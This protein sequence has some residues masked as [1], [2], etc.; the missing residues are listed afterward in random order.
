MDV[1]N[2]LYQIFYPYDI[3]LTESDMDKLYP[4]MYKES[5]KELIIKE[6]E[7]IIKEKEP[8]IVK[9]K[10]PIVKEKD[11][12]IKESIVKEKDPSLE[13]PFFPEFKNTMFWSIY[14][15]VHGMYEYSVVCHQNIHSSIE[16][17]VQQEIITKF[18]GKDR[19]K[20]LKQTNQ[21]ITLI[22]C[23]EILSDMMMK[24]NQL[25][26]LVAYALH[27]N[28]NIHVSF[29]NKKIVLPI[30]VD[31]TQQTIYLHF[32]TKKHKYGLISNIPDDFIVIE[33]YNKPLKGVSTYKLAEL[34]EM[35]Q[36]AGIVLDTGSKKEQM[37]TALSEYFY[38]RVV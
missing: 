27:Y 34:E 25:H 4:L 1:Y 19:I 26:V 38:V 23:Q 15:G 13:K 2:E 17:N 5:V 35:T 16:L 32:D 8:I 21:K 14:A 37:Y 24:G 12:T 11:K 20:Q 3:F 10:E 18:Q 30:I 33:Q 29:D 28:K 22:Q 31:T 9:E 7:Q 36:K 6:K